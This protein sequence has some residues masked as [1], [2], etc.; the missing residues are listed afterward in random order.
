MPASPKQISMPAFSLRQCPT[1]LLKKKEKINIKI[2][3]INQ[4][5]T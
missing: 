3:L 1:F 5:L 2:K 4:I